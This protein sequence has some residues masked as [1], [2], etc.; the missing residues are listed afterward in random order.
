MEILYFIIVT[1]FSA[2]T[3]LL[4]SSQCKHY[5]VKKGEELVKLISRNKQI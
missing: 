3:L 2:F 5:A 1:L 4:L